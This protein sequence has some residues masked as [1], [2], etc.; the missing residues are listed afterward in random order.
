MQPAP[1]RQPPE[2]IDEGPF[3]ADQIRDGDPYELSNGH[4]IRCMSA[5]GR[6][7]SKNF[8]GAKVIGTDPDVKSAG[9]DAAYTFNDGKNLRAPDFSVNVPDEPGWI[10]TAPPLAVEYADTGQD[11]GK[12]QEK[13][14]ELL[15]QGTRYIWVVRLVGPLRVEIYEP[16]KKMRV[17]SEGE[18][19]APGV[20]KNPVP[21]R[22]LVDGEAANQATLRNLLNRAG[23][24]S[25]DDVKA[26]A[27][28]QALLNVLR[29]R[30]L[31]VSDDIRARILACTDESILTQGLICA[32]TAATAAE[33]VRGW[34]VVRPLLPL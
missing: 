26:K 15:G 23:Y 17:V 3:R 24:A 14:A 19:T 22:A 29:A 30:G 25:L 27:Q 4:A 21:L 32:A 11:E 34:I 8:E 20:L 13:I 12:L 6:H 31:P 16:N 9:V 28:A 5:G 1:R 33:V 7:A 18:L 10:K 2:T